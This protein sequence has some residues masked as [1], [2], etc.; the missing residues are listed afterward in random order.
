[1]FAGRNVSA[2]GM[3]CEASTRQVSNLS[4][5]AAVTSGGETATLMPSVAND[6]P[7][8]ANRV[9]SSSMVGIT[10]PIRSRRQIARIVSR[11]C[12]EVESGTE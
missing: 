4:L 5:K 11:Y 1:M 8:S 7:A 3:P 6:A 2:T 12:G 10:S 9:S